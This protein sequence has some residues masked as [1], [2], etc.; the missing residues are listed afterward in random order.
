LFNEKTLDIVDSFY[1]EK[2]W[3]HDKLE[4]NWTFFEHARE[5]Y[6]CHTIHPHKILKVDLNSRATKLVYDEPY[7]CQWPDLGE[8]RGGTCPVKHDGLYWSFFHSSKMIRP[9]PW[10]PERRYFIGLY[11][12]EST[13]PFKPVRMSKQPL[14]AAEDEVPNVNRPTGHLVVFPCGNLR[15][16]GGWLVSFGDNDL[17]VRLAFFS[18]EYVKSKL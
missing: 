6:A 2:P 13:P 15:V 10:G 12:F 4:K 5:L 18:D 8:P 1:L 16:E 7:D 17:R 11:A 9:G 3:P 14:L